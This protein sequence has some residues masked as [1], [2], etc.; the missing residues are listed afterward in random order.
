MSTP[1]PNPERGPAPEEDAPL[2]L[3]DTDAGQSSADAEDSLSTEAAMTEAATPDDTPATTVGSE[4][5]A[6]GGFE[7]LLGQVVIRSGL[8]TEEE[9]AQAMAEV[10]TDAADDDR[11][12]SR[13]LA[14][15][16]VSK[17]YATRH[18]LDR[19]RND[20]EARRS[21]RSIPGFR[22]KRKLGAGAMATVFLAKQISLDRLVAI[23]VLPKKFTNNRKFIERFYKEGRAAAQLNHPNIVQA[24]DVGAAGEHHYFVMEYVDGPTVYDRIVE[25]RRFP[26]KE[27]IDVV[28]QVAKALEHAH[29]KGFI[30]R[31]VKPKNIMIT[32][33]G[34]VK[35]ADLGLARAL[36]DKD[37][38]EAEAG[39]AYGTPYY[40]S[41]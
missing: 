29:Q 24:Y 7:T 32:R 25:A 20:F 23:K 28:R 9:V 15:I 18:Q 39:R 34:R 22:I 11:E 3:A 5:A 4:T 21:G 8:A 31:D 36:S 38:A 12:I 2:S 16:L 37:A 33:T 14:E 40:I 30:H 1:S 6:T 17:Q 10:N 13:T 41:P 26:E 35:L 27:A 19:L